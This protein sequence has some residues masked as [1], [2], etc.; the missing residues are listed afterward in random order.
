MKCP[1]C[2]RSVSLFSPS[3]NRL[4]RRD[5]KC[6]HCG[7]SVRAKVRHKKAHLFCLG[8][9]MVIQIMALAVSPLY[10]R[11]VLMPGQAV[12]VIVGIVALTNFEV[13]S[14]ESQGKN[15]S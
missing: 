9:G 13:V 11:L 14:G 7:G 2:D 8:V 3:V 12:V 6:P 10:W 1:H 4:R 15:Q 5:R